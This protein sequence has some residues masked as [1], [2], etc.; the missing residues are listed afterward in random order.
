MSNKIEENTPL[1]W[2]KMEWNGVVLF[3]FAAA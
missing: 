2:A 3:V 1:G